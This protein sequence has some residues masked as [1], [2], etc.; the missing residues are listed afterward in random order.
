MFGIKKRYWAL[1]ILLITWG[2]FCQSEGAKMRYDKAGMLASL[3]QQ[4]GAAFKVI[5]Q[6]EH[7]THYLEIINSDTLPTLIFIHGSPGSLSAYEGLLQDRTLYKQFNMVSVDRPGFGFSDFGRTERSLKQQ[8]KQIAS[9]LTT[10]PA[11]PKILIGHSMGGPVAVKTAIVN[12]NLIDGLL[13]VAPSVS[14]ELEP[15]N[16]W[17]R[18]VDFPPFRWLTPAAMRVCNQEIIPLH[19]ELVQMDQEWNQLHIPII[20][21]QGSE[22]QLVPAGNADYIQEKMQGQ[23]HVQ[24]EMLM[25]KGHFILWEEEELLKS[26]IID[27][28]TTIVSEQ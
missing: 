23:G 12:P 14:P 18:L 28:A 22:D 3:P 19:Q 25:G 10:L 13:L 6:A 21:M 7:N 16:W 5:Q 24:I 9:I 26:L 1:L 2:I 17:R 15:G 27:L 4:K 11:T 8:A 20:V